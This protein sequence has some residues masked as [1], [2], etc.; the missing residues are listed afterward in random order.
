[1]ATT[2]TLISSVTVG[3]G[4]AANIQ[5]TSISGTYTDLLIKASLRTDQS[6]VLRSYKVQPNGTDITARRIGTEGNPQAPYSD[7]GITIYLNGTGATS[8]TFNNSEIYIPNY[9][10]TTTY[11]SSSIEAVAENN[12]VDGGISM[13]AGLYSSN[14]AITSITLVPSLGNFVQY[15][16]AYLYGISNA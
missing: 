3:S 4:G 15:S 2:Y 5:F 6:N 13:Q 1:M 16:T 12:G 11:K 9:A 14:N 8:S 7:T 10:S